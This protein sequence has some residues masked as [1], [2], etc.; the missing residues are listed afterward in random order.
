[1]VTYANITALL[2]GAMHSLVLWFDEQGN[3]ELLQ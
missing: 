3:I 2:F 1:M